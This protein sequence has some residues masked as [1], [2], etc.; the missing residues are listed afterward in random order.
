MQ[1]GRYALWPIKNVSFIARSLGCD[2][3][4]RVPLCPLCLNLL[5]FA[6]R[7]A[8][9]RLI[10][11]IAERT[12]KNVGELQALTFGGIVRQAKALLKEDADEECEHGEMADPELIAVLREMQEEGG[13]SFDG[14]SLCRDAV[15]NS[16]I[17][18]LHSRTNA[19]VCFA[20]A[21]HRPLLA[22]RI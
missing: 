13:E 7:L 22:K 17:I 21:R 11:K 2:T 20:L 14:Q 18:E 4:L 9:R 16:V 10:V 8:S 15:R 3:A 5:R 12:Q 1:V 19:A 6:G